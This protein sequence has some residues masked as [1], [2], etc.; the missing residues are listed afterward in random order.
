MRDLVECGALP[1]L[2]QVHYLVHAP[3]ARFH[4]WGL[5][6]GARAASSRGLGL[7]LAPPG[8][9]WSPSRESAAPISHASSP[10]RLVARPRNV[11]LRA[12]ST[13][14]AVRGLVARHRA[15]ST[16]CS[17]CSTWSKARPPPQGR[18]TQ[19]GPPAI[20]VASRR[21]VLRTQRRESGS[22]GPDWTHQS[23]LMSHQSDRASRLGSES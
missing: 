12:S 9:G 16:W 14:E 23:D 2:L 3:G 15:S 13:C 4:A 17:C 20:R 7:L 22:R 11:L 6:N 18:K 1:H 21:V 10:R 19:S 8:R 5:S